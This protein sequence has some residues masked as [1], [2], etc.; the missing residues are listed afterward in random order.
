MRGGG[1][2]KLRVSAGQAVEDIPPGA[3]LAV[4]GFGL[5]GVPFTLI[6]GLRDTGVADLTIYSNNLGID[7]VGPRA[8]TVE[9]TDFICSRLV[10]W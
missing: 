3:S 9:R 8:L 2:E 6:Q 4:G 5:C 7:D 1:A 10:R